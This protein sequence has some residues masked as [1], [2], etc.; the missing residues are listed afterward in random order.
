M[1]SRNKHSIVQSLAL[2]AVIA[3]AVGCAST[4]KDSLL[5][6]Q[7]RAAVNEAE[8]D[9]NVSKYAPADLQHARE[10]LSI[11][12][13]TA[14]KKGI[15]DPVAEHNA[16]SAT[17]SAHIA[18][19]RAHEQVAS[20]RIKAGEAER[21]QVLLAARENEADRAM[22]QARDAKS[23]AEQA[24]NEAQN[25][26][27]EALKAQTDAQ[28]A[29]AQTAQA[30]EESRR[31]AGELQAAQT[32]RGLVLTL[33]DVLFD[34]GRAELKPGAERSIDKLT[35]FLTENP[36]RKVEVEGF[37]DSQGTDDYNLQLSQRRADAVATAIMRRGIE[38]QRVRS[39]GYGEEYPV[40]GNDNAGSRQR[41]RRVEVVISNGNSP[42]P[43]R[44]AAGQ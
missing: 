7:A 20:A 6:T 2:G 14:K 19:Q 36:E 15:K 16:Y 11:A 12:E 41:N 28:T 29:Q 13:A 43:E 35:S 22:T 24:R 23:A 27:T 33:G 26:Q 44:T 32:T 34:T 38:A 39:R 4:P 42:I 8:S 31:L 3:G 1:N 18:E 9:P 37:T 5:M 21:Q 40:A 25:A 17:L 10:F 30:Q